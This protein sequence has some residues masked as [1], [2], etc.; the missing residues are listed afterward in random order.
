MRMISDIL[1]RQ[2]EISNF[3]GQNTFTFFCAVAHPLKENLLLSEE[4]A[5][6]FKKYTIKMAK[7]EQLLQFIKD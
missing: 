4:E 1:S 6:V 7:E 5:S 3:S 2:C